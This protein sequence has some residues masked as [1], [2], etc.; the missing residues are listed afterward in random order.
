MSESHM[1]ASN[2]LLSDAPTYSKTLMLI[3][4]QFEEIFPTGHEEKLR[5]N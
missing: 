3:A 1:L 2:I 5:K 4:R